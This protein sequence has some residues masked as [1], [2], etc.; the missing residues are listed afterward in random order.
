MSD[1]LDTELGFAR[2]VLSLRQQRQTILA[3]NIA[4][5]DTPG[6]QARDIDFSSQLKKAVSR[7]QQGDQPLALTLTSG[8]H[9]AAQGH[10]PADT[11]L[12]YRVPDQP[13]A[14]G[15]TVDMDRERVQFADN[16]VK[17]Q[18]DLTMLS[19]RIKQMISVLQ[20]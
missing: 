8:R 3:A 13:A 14:D 9:I 17:Y 12:L 4:N 18:T 1:R 5:A 11:R 20:G 19:G 2:Q 7:G 10:P 16:S 15:N 6:Y